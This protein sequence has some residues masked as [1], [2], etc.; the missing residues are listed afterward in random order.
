MFEHRFETPRTHAGYIEPRATLVWIDRAGVVHV[1][2]PNK[3]PF[4]LRVQMARTLGV[5]PERIVVECTSIGGDFGGKGLTLDEYVCY[6]LAKASGRP[7]RHVQT[8]GDELR[9]RTRRATKR[10]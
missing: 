8:Y 10:R 1:H 4:D 7:V 3:S 6:F 9:G 5:P 2:S